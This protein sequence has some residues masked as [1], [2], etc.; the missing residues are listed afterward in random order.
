MSKRLQILVPHYKLPQEE[1]SNLLDMIYVQRG[2]NFDDIGVIIANDGDLS[3]IDEEFLDYYRQK[4][5]VEYHILPHAGVSATRNRLIDLATADFIMFCDDDDTFLSNRSLK[6]LLDCTET[7]KSAN[8]LRSRYKYEVRY[9][10]ETILNDAGETEMYSNLHGMLLR[11]EFLVKNNI[12]FYERINV[13]EDSV[14]NILLG[15]HLHYE[16]QEEI[17]I[18]SQTYIYCHN[19]NSICKYNSD[20]KFDFVVRTT[21]V[22]INS[23]Y[24]LFKDLISRSQFNLL[25]TN[26]VNQSIVLYRFLKRLELTQPLDPTYVTPIFVHTALC[27]KRL[28]TITQPTLSMVSN[29]DFNNVATNLLAEESFNIPNNDYVKDFYRLVNYVNGLSYDD[30]PIVKWVKDPLTGEPSYNQTDVA[31]FIKTHNLST[32]S[33]TSLSELYYSR[34]VDYDASNNKEEQSKTESELDSIIDKFSHTKNAADIN[35]MI[36]E[37]AERA[38]Y[39]TIDV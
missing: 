18:N 9:G 38:G 12:R 27:F 30:D 32:D 4:F 5:D 13:H 25:Q 7:H 14:F 28:L 2:I 8:V 1:M 16:N 24:E 33:N 17:I 36:D 34:G 19:D 11:R 22:L 20:D 31:H 39:K 23:R 3:V 29:E 6:I 35:T 37:Y 10:N 15:S 21:D 26:I